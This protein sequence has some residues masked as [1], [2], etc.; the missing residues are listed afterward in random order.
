MSNL[1]P[2]DG[3]VGAGPHDPDEGS[4]A[5][6]LVHGRQAHPHGALLFHGNG[7]GSG[8][9]WGNQVMTVMMDA[10]VGPVHVADVATSL[11]DALVATRQAGF[12]LAH[13]KVDRY[14]ANLFPFKITSN[15]R[16][17]ISPQRIPFV[18]N[19][20]VCIPT[21]PFSFNVDTP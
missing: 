10:D 21:L 6:S 18:S 7:G 16:V 1:V 12:V 17:Q 8:G 19:G 9:C 4:H 15:D 2:R 20:N 14:T 13:S 5:K 3:L 11:P